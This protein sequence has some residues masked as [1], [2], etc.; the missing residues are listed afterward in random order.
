MRSRRKSYWLQ[1]PA[2]VILACFASA[3]AV[4]ARGYMTPG[5]RAKKSRPA[6]VVVLPPHAEFI[7]EKVIMTDQMVSEAAALEAEAAKSIKAQLEARGYKVRI[8]APQALDKNPNLRTLVKKLNDR[9]NEE[10]SRMVRRPKK[11]R[12]RRYIVGADV[13]RLCSFLKV[14]GV[15]VARIQAVGVSKGKATMRWV[16]GSNAPHSYAR[17]DVSILEGRQGGVEGYFFGFENTSLSQMAKKPAVVMGQVAENSLK[18]YPASTEVEEVSETDAVAAAD[19]SDAGDNE[20]AVKDFEA[21]LG[22]GQ[23]A[24][25]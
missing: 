14:D 13:V 2:L 12:E 6:T 20:D 3:L 10:W 19:D 7:K 1:I 9:Y 23:G 4:Y 17:M 18:K 5:F 15:A 22:P 24:S 11:V 21:L 25:K 16:A 8:L